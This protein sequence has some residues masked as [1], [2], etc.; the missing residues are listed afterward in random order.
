MYRRLDKLGRIVIPKEYR[1]HLNIQEGDVMA[2]EVVDSKIILQKNVDLAKDEKVKQTLEKHG[3][4]VSYDL[5][6]ELVDLI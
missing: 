1:K 3:I 2:M 6:K 4:L 5:L